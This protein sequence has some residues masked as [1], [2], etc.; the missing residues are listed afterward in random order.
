MKDDTLV[1]MVDHMEEDVGLVHQMPFVCDRIG[2]PATLEKVT[3]LQ[4]L[5]IFISSSVAN[6]LCVGEGMRTCT[7]N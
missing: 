2:F 7:V 3:L 6:E 1:D 5:F 4:S